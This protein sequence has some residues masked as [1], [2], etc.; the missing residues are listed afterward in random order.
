MDFQKKGSKNAHWWAPYYMSSEDYLKVFHSLAEL[1][2][3]VYL[4]AN[5]LIVNAFLMIVILSRMFQIPTLILNLYPTKYMKDST[6]IK[7]TA[8]LFG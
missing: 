4:W 6:E 1:F 2:F 5:F 8:G 7:D 3:E